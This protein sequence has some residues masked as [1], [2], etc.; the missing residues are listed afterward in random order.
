MYKIGVR[1]LIRILGYAIFFSFGNAISKDK[2]VNINSK[3]GFS[4]TR[5][6]HPTVILSSV[7]LANSL[8]LQYNDV[9][10]YQPVPNHFMSSMSLVAP[11]NADYSEDMSRISTPNSVPSEADE[12]SM[13]TLRRVSKIEDENDSTN[14]RISKPELNTNLEISREIVL[15]LKAYLDEAERDLFS[16]RWDNVIVYLNTFSEQEDAFANIADN[17]YPS[18]VDPVEIAANDALQYE[19]KVMFSA[20]EKLREA[21]RD[22]VVIVAEKYYAKLLLS[23]DR[24]LKAGDLYPT[25]DVITSTEIFFKN[26]DLATLRF[27]EKTVVKDKDNVVLKKGPDMGKKGRIIYID[28][29]NAII[30]LDKDGRDYQ[31][32]KRVPMQILA[33]TTEDFPTVIRKTLNL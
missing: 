19:A 5:K 18:T 29:D 6:F 15:T 17:L 32:V 12:S 11:A 30:K 14:K 31:E 10:K 3:H 25:Y 24:F 8:V 26:T 1:L 13:D 22:R 4:F 28:G 27:D 33:K 23:Y 2:H 7:I 20:L 9:S 21:V 16:K